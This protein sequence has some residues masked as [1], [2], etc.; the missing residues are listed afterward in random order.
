MKK[1]HAKCFLLKKRKKKACCVS[2]LIK[3]TQT[4]T[5]KNECVVTRLQSCSHLRWACPN[6]HTYILALLCSHP[7]STGLITFSLQFRCGTLTKQYL[8]DTSS[9]LTIA[10]KH[11]GSCFCWHC[12]SQPLKAKPL[13]T[14]QCIIGA[15]CHTIQQINPLNVWAW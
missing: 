15:L 10:T 7:F 13:W 4:K 8:I 12:L 11:Q 2:Q 14:Q 9:G 1:S 5:K 6:N 3:K